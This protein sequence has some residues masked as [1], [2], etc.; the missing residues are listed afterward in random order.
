MY[1]PYH[2]RSYV[3]LKM[4]DDER[5]FRYKYIVKNC[6]GVLDK[7]NLKVISRIEER[8]AGGGKKFSIYY[9]L[10]PSESRRNLMFVLVNITFYRRRMLSQG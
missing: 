7:S 5:T 4:M 6:D 2:R 3:R 8:W 10:I 1:K 9:K